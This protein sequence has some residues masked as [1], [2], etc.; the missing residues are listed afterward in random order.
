MMT[1][2]L[3]LL[4]KDHESVRSHVISAIKSAFENAHTLNQFPNVQPFFGKIVE[5][6]IS[7]MISTKM[8][9]SNML[10]QYADCVNTC[11]QESNYPQMQTV[12]AEL[13]S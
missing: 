4:E 13:C 6:T 2:F 1:M 3:E 10:V 5:V 7:H 8:M 9:Q 12:H 11:V